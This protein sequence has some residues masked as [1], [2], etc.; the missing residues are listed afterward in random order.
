MRRSLLGF[1]ILLGPFVVLGVLYLLTTS[2]IDTSRPLEIPPTGPI[3]IA[4]A[5]DV[6]I[7]DPLGAAERDQGF[8]AARSAVRSATFALANLEMNLRDAGD[9]PPAGTDA[10][11][12]WPW[13]SSREAEFLRNW[14]SM[15]SRSPTITQRITAWTPAST[16]PC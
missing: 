10:S 7:T 2:P 4:L 16:R 13:G 15:R 1:L 3:T 12:R 6:Q 11:S 8:V 14:D 5:G 9:P